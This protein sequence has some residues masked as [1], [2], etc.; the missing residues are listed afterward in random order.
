TTNSFV[1]TGSGDSFEFWYEFPVKLEPDEYTFMLRAA[2][3]DCDVAL[4]VNCWP[5]LDRARNMLL[6]SD[7][8]LFDEQ[9]V[10]QRSWRYSDNIIRQTR[11]LAGIHAAIIRRSDNRIVWRSG[12]DMVNMRHNAPLMCEDSPVFI[13]TSEDMEEQIP[14]GE[15]ETRDGVV[16]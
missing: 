14:C 8:Y 10:V 2:E 16:V 12:D 13:A 3:R 4:Y 15:G 11:H 7:G 6:K 1:P 5:V 9:S